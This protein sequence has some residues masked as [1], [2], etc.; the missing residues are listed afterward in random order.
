MSRQSNLLFRQSGLLSR[1]SGLF[2]R[3][4]LAHF[5][6]LCLLLHRLTELDFPPRPPRN[7][8]YQVLCGQSAPSRTQLDG[9]ARR[10]FHH[11]E[12]A[13]Y[14]NLPSNRVGVQDSGAAPW[15]YLRLP[16]FGCSRTSPMPG[17][18]LSTSVLQSSAKDTY[19][20][21]PPDIEP[22]QVAYVRHLADLSRGFGEARGS[23]FD[24]CLDDGL[25]RFSLSQDPCYKSRK[26]RNFSNRPVCV[27]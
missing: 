24:K 4:F 3:Q 27:M 26:K 25:T 8:D 19:L 16:R 2:W 21:K 18:K 12:Q 11:H 5:Q 13:M 10:S 1:H 6:L 23:D 22:C 7:A 15:Q 20:I 14:G 9:R 17:G